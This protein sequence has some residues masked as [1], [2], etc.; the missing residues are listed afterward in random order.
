[1]NKESR[2]N[3]RQRILIAYVRVLAVMSFDFSKFDWKSLFTMSEIITSLVVIV[4]VVAIRAFLIRYIRKDSEILERDQRQWI[5]RIKNTSVALIFVALVF[6]WAP[7]LHTFA[8]S[9]AAFAVALVIASKELIMCLMGALLRASNQP[10]NVGEW[11][12]IDGVTGEVVDFDALAFRLQEVDMDGKTYQYT[13]RIITIPNSKLFTANIE[14]SNFFRN[15]I[16]ED[17]RVT[18]QFTDIDP[19]IAMKILKEISERYFAPHRK[20]AFEFNKTL[21]RKAG[22]DIGMA[23]PVYDLTTSEL[24]HYQFHVRLFVPTSLASGIG[25]DISRDFLSRIHK[26]RKGIKAD[27]KEEEAYFEEKRTGA[28]LHTA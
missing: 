7:Q 10:F 4:G 13:G 8:I 9:I 1:M 22:L 25:A 18:V 2:H 19:A 16:Y 6:L 11:V 5:I 21:R 12:T 24:G 17:V 26:M 3:F 14:N 15:Y 28:A 20:K 27:Q 23:E